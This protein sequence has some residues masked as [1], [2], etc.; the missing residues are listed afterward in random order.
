[1]VLA[2][3]NKLSDQCLARVVTMAPRFS[4]CAPILK[5]LHCLLV[6]FRIHFKICTITFQTLKDNQPAYLADLAY[7]FGKNARNIYAPQ[8]QINLLFLVKKLRL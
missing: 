8:I 5:R 1:M 3:A 6:K 2:F 7:L 4:R